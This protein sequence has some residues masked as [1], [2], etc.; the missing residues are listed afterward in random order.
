MWTITIPD[1]KLKSVD[2]YYTATAVWDDPEYGKFAFAWAVNET[3]EAQEKFQTAIIKY[4]DEWLVAKKAERD[5]A[6]A[7]EAEERSAISEELLKALN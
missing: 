2:G 6:L 7:K 3:K 1:L 4:R 5:A